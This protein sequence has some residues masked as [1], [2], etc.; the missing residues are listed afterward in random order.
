LSGNNR[1]GYPNANAPRRKNASN[2][3]TRNL[4]IG[5]GFDCARAVPHRQ[6]RPV[7]DLQLAEDV[8]DVLLDRARGQ[9]QFEGDFLV[10]FGRR[11]QLRDLALPVGQPDV[12]RAPA[13]A[14][15]AAVFAPAGLESLAATGARFGT[16]APYCTKSA[17]A[18]SP[19]FRASSSLSPV[20]LRMSAC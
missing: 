16:H 19:R 20:S 15:R 1:F 4:G 11:D 17:H 5:L 10:A 18:I 8:E 3:L 7:R 2:S 6:L 9:T 12:W 13:F 14:L